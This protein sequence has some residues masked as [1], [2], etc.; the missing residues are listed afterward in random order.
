MEATME[1]IKK[2]ISDNP[3]RTYVLSDPKERQRLFREVRGYLHTCR[4]EHHGTDWEGRRFA[5]EALDALLA[6]AKC[7]GLTY[8]NGEH[9]EV[10]CPDCQP[11]MHQEHQ[12]DLAAGF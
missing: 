11:K 3:P 9:G 4:R 8:V 5:I 6:C 12:A 7:A 10:P 1:N 2:M